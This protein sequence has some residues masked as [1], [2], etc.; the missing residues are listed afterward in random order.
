MNDAGCFEPGAS[1]HATATLAAAEFAQGQGLM[2]AGITS[3]TR[4][5]STPR[6]RSSA[7]PSIPFPGGTSPTQADDLA[8]TSAA[9]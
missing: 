7:T 1:G 6:A 5:R 8:R 2:F 3:I 9:R 4:A